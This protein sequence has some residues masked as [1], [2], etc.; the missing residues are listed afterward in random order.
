M[1]AEDRTGKSFVVF[2]SD[3]ER[4]ITR[5]AHEM[6]KPGI[7][8]DENTC[9]QIV[10]YMG[11]GKFEYRYCETRKTEYILMKYKLTKTWNQKWT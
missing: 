4:V 11:A 6:M 10:A 9:G 2:E 7:S 3:R 5:A 8:V 1:L